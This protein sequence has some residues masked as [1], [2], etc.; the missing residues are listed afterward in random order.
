MALKRLY[1]VVDD[2]IKSYLSDEKVWQQFLEENHLGILEHWELTK[3]KYNLSQS[4]NEW[5]KKYHILFNYKS[6]H[7]TPGDYYYCISYKIIMDRQQKI[8]DLGL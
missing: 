4:M 6:F 7:I 3:N 2:E 8:T 5:D 1:Q